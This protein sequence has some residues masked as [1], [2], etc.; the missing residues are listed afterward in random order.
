M[1]E[2]VK[3]DLMLQDDPI[4]P[5]LHP[6]DRHQAPY[7]S[8]RDAWFLSA[9]VPDQPEQQRRWIEN[10]RHTYAFA[11]TCY[12]IEQALA[13][14]QRRDKKLMIALYCP[15]VDPATY[16]H[17]QTLRSAHCRLSPRQS[18]PSFRH[19]PRPRRRLQMLQP[20]FR[21][22]HGALPHRSLQSLPAITSL[23]TSIKKLL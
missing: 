8:G 9:D 18:D 14:T 12:I 23:P 19:E 5:R 2:A 22:L 16:L 20:A 1:Y 6:R 3:D 7:C 4:L 11:G 15:Q 13:F 10:L 17:R 21:G